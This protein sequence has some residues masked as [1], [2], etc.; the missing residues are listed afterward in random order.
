[1]RFTGR[2]KSLA[3]QHRRSWSCL[4]GSIYS[5]EAAQ[6][7]ALTALA[8]LINALNVMARH[9]RLFA[10][11]WLEHDVVESERHFCGSVAAWR[12]YRVCIRDGRL[13]RS[14]VRTSK[15]EPC[16]DTCTVTAP[17]G[18]R[19]RDLESLSNWY[20]TRSLAK[21]RYLELELELTSAR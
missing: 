6:Q 5:S 17:A 7:H 11:A 4:P 20:G 1:M 14:D 15:R 16:T 9:W 13:G 12:M 18:L 19:S 8:V 2:R 3:R 10:T 21:D